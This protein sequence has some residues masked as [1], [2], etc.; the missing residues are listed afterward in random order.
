MIMH[1]DGELLGETRDIGA[2]KAAIAAQPRDQEQRRPVAVRLVVELGA[3]AE[4]D[5]WHC[6]PFRR[7]SIGGRVSG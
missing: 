1:D 5:L 6:I 4:L 3:V 2:P 7:Y